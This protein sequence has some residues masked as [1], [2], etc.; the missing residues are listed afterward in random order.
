MDRFSKVILVSIGLIAIVAL[1]DYQTHPAAFWMHVTLFPIILGI[2]YYL[3]KKDLSESIAIVL[4]FAIM[5]MAG[6]EDLIYYLVQGGIPASMPHLY[7]HVVIGKFAKWMN[8]TTVTPTSL[9]VSVLVGAGLT[10]IIVIWLR[11]QHW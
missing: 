8:L 6:L 3:F 11:K 10:Y 4:A 9:L 2:T 5:M 1:L 7:S